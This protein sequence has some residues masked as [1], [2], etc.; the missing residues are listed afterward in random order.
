MPRAIRRPPLKPRHDVTLDEGQKLAIVQDARALFAHRY[1]TLDLVG[2]A[3]LHWTACVIHAAK[4]RGKR[5][6]I[7]AGT[8]NF[9]RLPYEQDDGVV[10][11][12]FSYEWSTLERSKIAQHVVTGTLPEMHVWAGDLAEQAIVDL[13]TGALATECKARSGL[14]WLTPT[15]PSFVWTH[16]LPTGWHYRPNRTATELA[17]ML[18]TKL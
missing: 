6:V 15:P 17:A 1:R 7:Q 5:L 16:R 9:L 2:G 4:R 18:L 13:S 3:C 8:A 12:H 14:P 11:T 10:A